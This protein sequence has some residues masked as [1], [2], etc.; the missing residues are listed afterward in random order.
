MWV[1]LRYTHPRPPQ[2]DKLASYPTA[3]ELLYSNTFS[4][5][6][7]YKTYKTRLAV[8]SFI[9]SL[10]RGTHTLV[11]SD[12]CIQERGS[13]ITSLAQS[14]RALGRAPG[15]GPASSPFLTPAWPLCHTIT[16]LCLALFLIRHIG[17]NLALWQNRKQTK[18][19]MTLL[20][21][22]SQQPVQ[23]RH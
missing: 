11:F 22:A 9:Y 10:Q 23:G 2:A 7:M 5:L 4:G 21:T 1:L 12:H 20:T 18:L 17:N 6:I 8:L 3:P 16:Q 15:F 19:L 13:I 14:G